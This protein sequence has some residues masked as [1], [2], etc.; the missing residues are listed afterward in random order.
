MQD[1]GS[2]DS[3]NQK[4]FNV[5]CIAPVTRSRGVGSASE[6]IIDISVRGL[7]SQDGRG[8]LSKCNV[9]G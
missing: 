2:F 4:C 6:W 8:S 5:N 9:S 3:H 1:T 7:P